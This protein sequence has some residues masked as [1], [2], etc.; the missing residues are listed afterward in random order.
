MSDFKCILPWTHL[1]IRADSRIPPC[2]R[3][4]VDEIKPN[5][6]TSDA[7]ATQG[8][9]VMNDEFF[10]T[11]RK[12]MLHNKKIPNCEACYFQE[13]HGISSLRTTSNKFVD[14]DFSKLTESFD[15]LKFL[16]IAFTNTCNL[17]CRMCNSQYSTKLIPRDTFLKKTAKTHFN[18]D[19][20]LLDNLDLSELEYVKLLGGEPFVAPVLDTILDYF[21]ANANYHDITLEFATNATSFPGPEIITKLQLFKKTILS[22]SIDSV[23]KNNNYQRFGSDVTQTIQNAFKLYDLFPGSTVHSVITNFTARSLSATYRTFENKISLSFAFARFPEALSLSYAPE[24]F[25]L[26]VL[27][28]NDHPHILQV[29]NSYFKNT[30]YNKAYWNS[31]IKDIIILDNYYGIHIK[32]YDEKL[33]TFLTE[34]NYL[35]NH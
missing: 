23:E 34:H 21:I 15:T 31:F 26:W 17:E 9:S 18:F 30:M 12:D 35:K 32:D 8:I 7:L 24:P 19:I 29:L 20:T 6:T 11:L 5:L 2:C 25:K 10:T 13:S 14:A 27:E 22:I 28:S 3:F 33:Y 4:N 16:E 1:C